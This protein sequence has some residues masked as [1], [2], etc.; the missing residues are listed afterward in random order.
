MQELSRKAVLEQQEKNKIQIESIL[1]DQRKKFQEFLQEQVV[2]REYILLDG[3][4]ALSTVLLS[5]KQGFWFFARSRSREIQ[6]N[7]AKFTKTHKIPRNLVKILSN[8][9]LYNIF[10][11]YFSYKRQFS[12]SLKLIFSASVIGGWVL[13]W[14]DSLFCFGCCFFFSKIVLKEGYRRR[15]II[16]QRKPIVY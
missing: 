13:T 1:E 10:E 6:V 12:I 11:T 9:C 14:L 5:L 8:R 2:T 15:A 3:Q 4:T 7:P 16:A